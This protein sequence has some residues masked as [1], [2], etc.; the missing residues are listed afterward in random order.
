M[1]QFRNFNPAEFTTNTILRNP[2]TGTE[3]RIVDIDASEQKCI[4][5]GVADS[6]NV[7]CLN[8]NFL[9]DYEVVET[10]FAE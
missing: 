4:L 2:N 8:F 3:L 6:T 5:Q 7:N 1:N 9:S 10:G